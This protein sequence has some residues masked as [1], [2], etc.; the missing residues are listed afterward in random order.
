MLISYCY[1]EIDIFERDCDKGSDR[2]GKHIYHIYIY[3]YLC[4]I[5]VRWVSFWYVYFYIYV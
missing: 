5:W 2:D 1:N 3:I 4:L